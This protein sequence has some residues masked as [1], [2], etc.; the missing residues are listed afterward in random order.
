MRLIC[1]ASH[2]IAV[3]VDLLISYIAANLILG[4]LLF[5]WYYPMSRRRPQSLAE[6]LGVVVFPVIGVPYWSYVHAQKE[7]A[8]SALPRD[9]YYLNFMAYFKTG[10]GN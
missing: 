5:S 8:A 7:D 2:P 4:V 9:W 10:D 6:W 1:A 3:M